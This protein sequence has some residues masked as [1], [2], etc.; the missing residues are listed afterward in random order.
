MF[1]SLYL[2]LV[3]PDEQTCRLARAVAV[4]NEHYFTALQ[5]TTNTRVS[6]YWDI[7]K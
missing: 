7:R 1:R 4:A 2:Y 3:L 6:V 5:P